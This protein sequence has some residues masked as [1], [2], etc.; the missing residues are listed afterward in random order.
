[1]FWFSDR[2]LPLIA[3]PSEIYAWTREG[4]KFK[5]GNSGARLVY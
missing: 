3:R 2:D 4:P 5:D 1:M